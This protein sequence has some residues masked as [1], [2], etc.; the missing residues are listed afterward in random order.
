MTIKRTRPKGKSPVLEMINAPH[1]GCCEP[2]PDARF[3]NEQLVELWSHH[4]GKGC[5]GFMEPISLEAW[6]AEIDRRASAYV[7][8]PEPVPQLT[9]KKRLE[10]TTY[11]GERPGPERARRVG[12]Q[13]RGDDR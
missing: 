2:F 3:E 4:R 12:R 9:R 10:M 1:P 13:H 5:K 6:N 11:V 8:I 7:D